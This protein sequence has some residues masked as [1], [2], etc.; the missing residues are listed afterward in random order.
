MNSAELEGEG[1]LGA[2]AD[3]IHDDHVVRAIASGGE[4]IVVVPE[5][6]RGIA[7]AAAVRQR[8]RHAPLLIVTPTSSEAEML[9]GQLEVYGAGRVAWYPAWET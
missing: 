2:L 7:F 1:A 6:G 4:D 9:A 3:L 5:V 8:A